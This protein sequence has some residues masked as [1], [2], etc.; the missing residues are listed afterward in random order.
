MMRTQFGTPL[1]LAG[2]L[3]IALT[4]GGAPNLFAGDDDIVNANGF[5]P[6]APP[7]G[8]STTF[9]TT[10]QLEGQFN[11]PGSGQVTSPGQWLRTKGAGASTA[12]V[13]NTV[14]APGGGNQAVKVDRAAAANADQRW[15]VPVDALGYPDYPNPAPPEPAQPCICITWDMRVQGPAGINNGNQFGPFFGVE[16]YD[17]AGNPIALLGSLGVDATTGDVLYQAAGT[18]VLTET[19]KVVSFGQWNRFQIKLDYSTHQYTTYVNGAL[20]GAI[21][22]FVDNAAYPGQLNEFSDG[23]IAALAAAGDPTSLAM[24]GTAYY[25]NFLIREGSC[26]VPEPS[27][28]GLGTMLVATLF[29]VQ[30]RR[31]RHQN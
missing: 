16:A 31:N 14:F 9:L 8:F 24:P 30:R 3:Q 28:V 12:V 25:D 22:T 29:G 27:M 26:S 11:P 23:D 15:A 21:T 18:G 6:S 20:V 1:L 2:A 19:G 10:G 13:Q 7:N 17:D 4:F 5:E